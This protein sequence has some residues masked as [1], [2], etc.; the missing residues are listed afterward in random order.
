VVPTETVYANNEAKRSADD[1]DDDTPGQPYKRFKI[2]SEEE[3][4]KW[5]LSDG[6]ATYAN[7]LFETYISDKKVKEAVFAP[8]PL[9][10]KFTSSQK[11]G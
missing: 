10:W 5:S 2:D 9:S 3:K 8:E 6:M 7:E 4:Y 11:D 1:G